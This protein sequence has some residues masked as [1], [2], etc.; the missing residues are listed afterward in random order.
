MLLLA[1]GRSL[2]AARS[3][4][5]IVPAVEV[6]AGRAC[7]V[8]PSGITHARYLS[9]T[10]RTL[11]SMSNLLKAGF[12]PPQAPLIRLTPQYEI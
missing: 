12:L 9:L 3:R 4:V 11:M 5:S 7:N 2:P 10:E 6:F 8:R 1:G